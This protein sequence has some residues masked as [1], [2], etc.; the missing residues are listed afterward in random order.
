MEDFIKFCN[1]PH[2]IDRRFQCINVCGH[3]DDGSVVHLEGKILDNSFENL[4]FMVLSLTIMMEV[5]YR[6]SIYILHTLQ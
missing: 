2:P 6:E 3:D 1:A 5:F 4:Y